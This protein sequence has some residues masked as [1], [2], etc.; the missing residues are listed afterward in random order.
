MVKGLMFAGI[1]LFLIA[2]VYALSCTETSITKQINAGA[3]PSDSSFTCTNNLDNVV[4]LFK[5]GN[6][7]SDQN[8][9]TIQNNSQK[10]ITISFKQM[11]SAG[12]FT[13]S[14]FSSDGLNIPVIINVNDLNPTG[15]QI[16]PSLASYTQAV[17]QGTVLP[18]PKITF[19]PKN[20]QGSMVFDDS[21]IYIEGG[22]IL[23]GI[24]KP[25]T[26][27]S[28]V[29][30]GV[31][32]DINTEGLSSQTYSS[33]L[34]VNAF[35]K[36]FEI[37]FTIIVTAGSSP[38]TNFSV[39]NLPTCSLT[40]INLNLNNTYS[41]VCTNLQPD[42]T[43]KP[44]IDNDYIYG[45]G[46]DTT[47]NQYIWYFKPKKMGNTIIKAEFYYRD[48]PV[49]DPFSQEVKITSTGSSIAGTSLKLLFTPSLDVLSD[50]EQTIIQ[51]IDNK[52]NSLVEN[53]SVYVN[54]IPITPLNNSDKSFPYSFN[55]DTNYEIRGESPGYDDLVQTV[56]ITKKQITI[57]L[58]PDKAI[59]DAGEVINITTDPENSTILIDGFA[60]GNSYT[61]LKSGNVSIK[62]EK[63][64]YLDDEKIIFVQSSITLVPTSC[65]I[66]PDKWE[67]GKDVV[68][69]LSENSTWEIYQNGTLENSG[70][71]DTV[72]FK[73]KEGSFEIK[74]NGISIWNQNIQKKGIMNWV[75]EHWLISIIGVFA[76]A[77]LGYLFYINR[78]SDDLGE[79]L[80]S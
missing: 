52:T 40:S 49:G 78:G 70:T 57:T 28:I 71:S 37:P 50:G 24:R 18:L 25:I 76:I 69:S 68:C 64:G 55:T 20:C 31:N 77:F 63:E 60:S 44:V 73:L 45:N 12:N 62:A 11:T 8:S 61:A 15:C 32:M 10:D 22:I 21:H 79:R 51:L 72:S 33:K 17:Q 36:I 53:P 65:T 58:D 4:T 46:L 47:S 23:N 14:L 35:D 66:T 41:M 7:F 43:I 19:S 75:K 9:I 29:S 74:A 26:I 27:T 34:K 67:S 1:F 80:D 39:D 16:N 30:D 3:T 6:F 2:S 54:A 5:N 42:I 59:Y 56:N 38:V 48:S 13:G